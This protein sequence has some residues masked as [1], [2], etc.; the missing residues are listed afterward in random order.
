MGEAPKTL[1]GWYALHDYRTIDWAS[2]KTLTAQ[3]QQEAI[4]E[5][6][7]LTSTWSEINGTRTGAFGQFTAVGHK[8]DLLFM[9][10]RP[11][12]E[13]LYEVKTQL[14]KTMLADYLQTPYSY[15]S[16]VEL[17][18]YM[19]KPGVD[20]ETDE[21]LQSRLKPEIPE[22]P[23]I[24]F[25]PMN[26]KREG[27][28]NWYMTPADE[29]GLMLRDHGMIGRTYADKVKQIITGSMGLDDWEWGVTLFAHDVLQFKKLIYEMRFDESS[30]RFAEFGPFLLGS[31][32]DD[33]GFAA[34]FKM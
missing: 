20:A 33:A 14:N 7:A 19:A 28:D 18:S 4:A 13:E 10:M 5:F 3:E 30:A 21:Y 15:F 25:Y 12:M 17:G 24:C 1:E 26:K 34:I 22:M 6:M 11:T 27:T 32:L 29:R 31:R 2:F 9:H 23:H 8:A 16:I